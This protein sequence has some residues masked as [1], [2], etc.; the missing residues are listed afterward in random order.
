MTRVLLACFWCLTLSYST[1]IY[2]NATNLRV[3]LKGDL[4]KSIQSNIYAHLGE[5]PKNKTQR[6]SFIFSAKEN[7]EV[8]LQALGYY[9]SNIALSTQDFKD[10]KPWVLTIDV[11]LNKPTRVKLIDINILGEAQS[12]PAFA[13]LLEELPISENDILNHRH[14]EEIKTRITSLGLSRGYFDGSLSKS[15]LEIN[16]QLNQAKIKITYQSGYRYKYGD[17]NFSPFEI[18]PELLNVLIPFK[19]GDEFTTHSLYQLQDQLQR[20]QY[21]SNSL[22]M[23]DV[24]ASKGNIVPINVNLSPTKSHF[25]DVGLGYGSDTKFRVSAG[26]RTPLLNRYGHKQETKIEYSKINP[27]GRFTY[28][29]PLSH[30]VDDLLQLQILAKDDEYGDISSKSYEFKVGNVKVLNQWNAQFYLRHLT[31]NWR[32]L[33]VENNPKA[34]FLLPGMSW[35]HTRRA[36]PALDPSWGFSQL[37]TFEVASKEAYSEIDLIRAYARWRFITTPLDRHRVVMRA[38][39][40][41]AFIDNDEKHLL[42][43]SLRFFAGGSQSIRGFDYNSLGSNI[44]IDGNEYGQDTLVIGGTQLAVASIEYQ[45]YVTDNIRGVIFSDGGNADEKEKFEFVY[46]VGSGIHYISPIGA[47]RMDFGYTISEDDPSWKVHINLGM[48]L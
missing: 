29:I 38:E 12:D 19:P 37:Y 39:L 13:E 35:T 46:S 44:P 4:S 20:T 28:S 42:A 9:Q 10:N 14:Y 16:E 30:P 23:P 17:I 1:L 6:T 24:E 41:S 26:W 11:T 43:P 3:E 47:L 8:A 40:G 32:L 31:E 18:E 22:V 34:Q 25:F 5:L 15:R 48:E 2:A 36:G 7:T 21:F 33:T 27:T 45:Y